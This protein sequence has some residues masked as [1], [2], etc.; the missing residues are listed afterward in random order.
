MWRERA[1]SGTVLTF[2]T[3]LAA[4]V[5]NSDSY[6]IGSE[7]FTDAPLDDTPATSSSPEL[8][9]LPF[10]RLPG[11]TAREEYDQQM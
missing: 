11:H 3:I 2:F 5:Q 7:S 9:T 8:F 6:C 4:F 1:R 10:R